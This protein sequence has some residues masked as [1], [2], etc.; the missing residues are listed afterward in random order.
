MLEWWQLH[1]I[2]A[3]LPRGFMDTDKSH[4][5]AKAWMNKATYEIERLRAALMFYRDAWLVTT[6]GKI[7]F[8]PDDRLWDDKG[9]VARTALAGE[10]IN[11]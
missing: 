9:K 4:A 5:E 10:K 3:P 2:I 11:D 6:E 7:P 1:P 8:E